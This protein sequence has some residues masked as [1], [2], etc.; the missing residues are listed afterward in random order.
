M[1][2]HRLLPSLLLALAVAAILL[3]PPR[4]D[5][6]LTGFGSA[7]YVDAV[8]VAQAG[9]VSSG[10][11]TL[12]GAW[13]LRGD[14]PDFHSLSALAID[15]QGNF[16]GATD[17]GL[18][19]RWPMPGHGR[20]GT[21]WPLDRRADGTGNRVDAEAIVLRDDGG[22]WYAMEN[23]NVIVRLGPDGRLVDRA[24]PLEMQKWTALRGPEA[25]ARLPDGRM[26]VLG[27]GYERGRDRTLPGLVFAGDPA[28]G[29]E[30]FLFHLSM[31]EGMRPVDAAPLADGRLLI[32]GRRFRLPFGFE[33]ALYLLD[34]AKLRPAGRVEARRI[35]HFG[36][37][38]LSDNFEGL[39][40]QQSADGGVT[41]W[42]VSD[43]NEA[44]VLQKTLLLKLHIGKGA[45]R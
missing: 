38:G 30:P 11:I 44:Q 2:R 26:L 17:R 4:V 27:E 32:L 31:A 8:P 21:M 28:D 39:A 16:V 18:G 10:G 24:K 33:S 6:E 15:P 29:A 35:G 13:E 7:V 37:S 23:Q 9:F 45:L 1:I 22:L 5:P 20:A 12:D 25:M 42:V 43:N 3:W 19:V 34:T 14:R 36:G 41:A 40:I